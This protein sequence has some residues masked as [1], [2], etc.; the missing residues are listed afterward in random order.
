MKYWSLSPKLIYH[1]KELF[2]VTLWGTSGSLATHM[3]LPGDDVANGQQDQEE[4]HQHEQDE[5]EVRARGSESPSLV[6]RQ[7]THQT[8]LQ[9]KRLISGVNIVTVITPLTPTDTDTNRVRS[10]Q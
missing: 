10:D 4:C 5:Q 9:R 2:D 7:V 8:I 3:W 1:I 6:R